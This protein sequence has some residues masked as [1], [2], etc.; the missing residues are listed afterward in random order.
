MPRAASVLG[1]R[2]CKGLP[3]GFSA[4]C[5]ACPGPGRLW[6]PGQTCRTGASDWMIGMDECDAMLG[7]GEAAEYGMLPGV[8]VESGMQDTGEDS[9]RQPKSCGWRSKYPKGLGIC[10]ILLALSHG[11]GGGGPEAVADRFVELYYAAANLGEALELADGLAAKKIQDQQRLLRGQTGPQSSP[12]RR[13]G[14]S[15]IEKATMDGK[16]FF[17][18]EVR[19]DLQGGG[20]LARKSLVALSQGPNGWRVTNFSETE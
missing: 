16:L 9:V 5:L 11:C 13:V 14:F 6:D 3:F 12:G 7:V 18:Y 20:T 10:L 8:A 2:T 19:I 1:R 4:N 15:R 17:R